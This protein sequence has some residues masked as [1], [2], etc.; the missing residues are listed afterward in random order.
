[1]SKRFSLRKSILVYLFLGFLVFA[2]LLIF[3]NYYLLNTNLFEISIYSSLQ[4]SSDVRQ[5]LESNVTVGETTL[6][7]AEAYMEHE[8]ISCFRVD[9][10]LICWTAAPNKYVGT[11]NL[12]RDWLNYL[13]VDYAYKIELQ[14]QDSFLANVVVTTD[15][16][17][18]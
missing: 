4:S 14:F 13:F 15:A 10:S 11:D 8:S 1:M 18:F 6:S 5:T 9:A 2:G 3:A 17:G 7:E 12:L 16:I